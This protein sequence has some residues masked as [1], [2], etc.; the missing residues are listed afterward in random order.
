MP[1]S[2]SADTTDGNLQG[3]IMA[4]IQKK[5]AGVVE[6][7]TSIVSSWVYGLLIDPPASPDMAGGSR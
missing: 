4:E 2:P 6:R 5:F 7:S 3:R 1:D